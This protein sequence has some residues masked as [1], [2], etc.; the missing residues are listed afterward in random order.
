MRFW[1]P[2]RDEKLAELWPTHTATQ[3]AAVLGCGP[4]A[5]I[6]RH[7]RLIGTVFNGTSGRNYNNASRLE[8]A[9]IKNQQIK[10]LLCRK[11]CYA[12]IQAA[13]GVGSNRVSDVAHGRAPI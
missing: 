10:K 7:H 6:G 2:E 11:A 13:L 3:I 8:R 12:E 1:T 5:V 4:G 9:K